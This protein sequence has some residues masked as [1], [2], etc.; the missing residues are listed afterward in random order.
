MSKLIKLILIGD[1]NVG[2]SSFLIKFIHDQFTGTNISTI[3]IDFSIKVITV[4]NETVKLQ[5]WDTAG[6]ERF[7]TITNSYYR[8]AEGIIL[9]FDLT[10]KS[11]FDNLNRWMKD[12]QNYS[13]SNISVVLVGNKNDE[14]TNKYTD[15]SKQTTQISSEAINEFMKKYNI[16]SFFETSTK[17]GSNVNEVFEEITRKILKSKFVNSAERTDKRLEL[18][19]SNVSLKRKSFMCC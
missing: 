10:D 13:R 14:C 8:G 16:V 4:D 17:D 6:Q 9:M 5:I 18:H 2:K 11:S 7:R 1:T 19:D 12:I 15:G 3:G